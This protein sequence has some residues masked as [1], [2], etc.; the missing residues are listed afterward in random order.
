[1]FIINKIE[2]CKLCSARDKCTFLCKPME[3]LFE[4]QLNEDRTYTDRHIRRV[5]K[6]TEP[7]NI[8]R[9]GFVKVNTGKP[10]R[11]HSR[12]WVV[13]NRGRQ[14]AKYHSDDPS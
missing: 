12:Q 7:Q 4:A 5:E 11:K 9:M 13:K 8:D 2:T 6:A 3:A 14:K 1:M 10:I